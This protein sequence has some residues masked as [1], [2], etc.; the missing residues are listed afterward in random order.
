[1]RKLDLRL[2]FVAPLVAAVL[3]STGGCSSTPDVNLAAE[4]KAIRDTEAEFLKAVASKNVEKAVAFYAEDA[5]TMDP[6]EAMASGKTAIRA[7]FS[8]FLAQPDFEL[9]WTVSKVEVAKS[10][11]MAY[12]YGAYVESRKDAAGKTVKDHGKYAT[13]WKKQATGA[14]KAVLD[15]NNSDVPVPSAAAKKA[16]G[17][18]PVQTTKKSK[19]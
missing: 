18:K 5:V 13:I 16:S 17:K 15:T 12:D 6:G 2:A 10:G 1:M 4:E 19:R 11:D 9:T 7:S 8:Q 14:W 3:L